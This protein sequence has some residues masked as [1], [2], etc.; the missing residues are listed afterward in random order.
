MVS[1]PVADEPVA[2]EP[3]FSLALEEARRNFDSLNGRLTD[4]RNRSIQ[5]ISVGGLAAAFVGGLSALQKNGLSRLDVIAL[6]AF[7]LLVVLCLWIWAWPQK[8]KTSQ[9]PWVLVEWAEKPGETRQSM[10][11]DLA[12]HLGA[13]YGFNKKI[14]NRMLAVFCVSA[15]LLAAEVFCLAIGLWIN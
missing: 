10:N 3:D 7:A 12:L 1:E 13:H 4:L 5:L 11:K 2:D 6:V 15:A 14:I 8:L 9:K